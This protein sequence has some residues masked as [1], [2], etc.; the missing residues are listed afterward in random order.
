LSRWRELSTEEEVHLSAA[1]TLPGIGSSSDLRDFDARFDAV[2]L[3]PDFVSSATLRA[4]RARKVQLTLWSH[5]LQSRQLR[6]VA[7]LGPVFVSTGDA[8]LLRRWLSD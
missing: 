1:F 8:E 2:S 5:S 3:P 7:E 4:L 6:A